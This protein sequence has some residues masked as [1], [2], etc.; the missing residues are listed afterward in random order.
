[1]LIA[2]ENVVPVVGEDLLFYS[3][4]SKNNVYSELADRYADYNDLKL[5]NN[6]CKDL[7]ST[8]RSHPEFK[9]NPYDI[10]QDIGEIFEDWDPEIPNSLIQLAKIKHFN[11]FV[12]TS[13]DN[14]LEKAINQER[15]NGKKLTKVL[16]YSPKG[17]PSDRQVTEALASGD[18]VIFQLFGNYKNPLQF[19]LTEGDKVEYMH[20]LQSSEYSPKRMLAELQERPLLLL[21][22]KF[23]DWL[24]RS[25]L[26]MTRK[27]PLDHK[28]V[29]KQY[30]ADTVAPG[31]T[32]L[33]S[34]LRSFTTNTEFVE[35]QGGPI[36]FIHDL[37]VKWQ[38]KFLKQSTELL[39]PINNNDDYN[40]PMPKNAVFIS[41]CSE[42]G[43]EAI[44]L[45]KELKAANIE[46]WMDIEQLRAGDKYERKIERYINTCSVFIPMISTTS[47]LRT[48]GFFRR[49]WNW[50]LNRL[51][52]FTG[53]GRQ[54][55]LPIAL[56]NIDPYSAKVPVAFKECQF[57]KHPADGSFL[58]FIKRVELI[59][60]Y[61]I[62][63]QKPRTDD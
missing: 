5:L 33:K 13:F 23:P 41:Y 28:D 29:P 62:D 8:V 15:F 58:E 32:D 47:E 20:A 9:E 3:D 57:Y 35:K 59:Y 40:K 36:Q 54:F 1:M 6:Q 14:L 42:D 30:F 61:S 4:E 31:N 7:S 45:S 39:E 55:I 22:N 52:S 27:T 10:Y 34:F 53:A 16:S 44:A 24:A 2:K 11:L 25:F 51:P 48:E 38:D 17:I 18:P 60:R 19:A 50:A 21:G 49:E 37:S 63:N 46:V 43:K 56:G 12:S 26:R